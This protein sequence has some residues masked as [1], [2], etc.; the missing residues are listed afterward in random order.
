MSVV[1]PIN[2]MN[3]NV[4]T[5]EISKVESRGQLFPDMNGN[6][7]GNDETMEIIFGVIVGYHFQD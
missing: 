2:G 6:A 3:V 5:I 7:V 1:R 4:L